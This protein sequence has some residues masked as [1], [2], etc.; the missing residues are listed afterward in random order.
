MRP[1][2]LA[3]LETAIKRGDSQVEYIWSGQTPCIPHDHGFIAAIITAWSEHLPLVLKPE[4]IWLLI[5]QGIRSQVDADPEGLRDRFVEFRGKK[6][7]TVVRNEFVKG[8]GTNDWGGAIDD[9]GELLDKHVRPEPRAV[10]G[11]QFSTGTCSDSLCAR[12]TAMAMCK[13]FFD[14][15]CM[16]KCGFPTVT[17]LGGLEEWQQL[18]Q[19]A[20]DAI[21]SLCAEY[22]GG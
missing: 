13:H 6:T 9:F 2:S 12:L 8:S 19:K 22:L 18:R 21:T 11:V 17:L 16:T 3:P 5:L 7:L 10:F 14:Y 15:R 1:M 20:E 4:H